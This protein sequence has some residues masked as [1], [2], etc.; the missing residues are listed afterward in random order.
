[1][2]FSRTHILLIVVV[3]IVVIFMFTR[4]SGFLSPAAV[5]TNLGS[6]FKEIFGNKCSGS[7]TPGSAD[8]NGKVMS[9]YYTPGLSP[10]GI[11]DDQLTVNE[12]MDYKLVGDDA[13]LGD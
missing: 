13:Q 1:M 8:E 2:K 3:L 12:M 10:C 4:T 11:C 7:C 9:S 5:E 6:E